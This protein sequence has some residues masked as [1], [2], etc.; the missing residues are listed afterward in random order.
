M[1]AGSGGVA[2]SG[3]VKGIDPV[4]LAH[5][6]QFTSSRRGVEAFV[7]PATTVTQLTIVL[8]AVDGEWT[9]RRI[10]SERDAMD[11]GRRLGIPIYDVHATGYPPRMREWTRAQ[12]VA[13][14]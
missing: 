13:R 9:R 2:F 10:G 6:E 8:V 14:S 7:E 3:K 5:L 1:G 12:K 4:A 11:L